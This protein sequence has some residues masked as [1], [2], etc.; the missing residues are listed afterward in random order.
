MENK[1]NPDSVSRTECLRVHDMMDKRLMEIEEKQ[2]IDGSRIADIH[3]IITNGLRKE[4]TEIQ[5]RNKWLFRVLAVSLIG[6]IVDIILRLV[7][8]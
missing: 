4:V 5:E 2:K 7:L 3:A 6:L 1:R 8:S